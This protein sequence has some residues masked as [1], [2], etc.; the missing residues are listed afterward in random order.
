MSKQAAYDSTPVRG[1]NLERQL[2]EASRNGEK[3]VVEILLKR[4]VCANASEYNKSL[5]YQSLNYVTPVQNAACHGFTEI[6]QILIN[7]AGNN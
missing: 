2:V 6:L 5:F 3:E 4:G 1:V 7:A